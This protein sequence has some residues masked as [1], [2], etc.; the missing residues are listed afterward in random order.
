MAAFG[1]ARRCRPLV[2]A[3]PRLLST[4]ARTANEPASRVPLLIGGDFVDSAGEV[5]MPVRCPAT[6]RLLATAPQA[7]LAEMNAAV[8]AASAAF[9][10][11]SATSIS[12]RARV[13]FKLQALIREH[14]DELASILSSEHGKTIEDAKGDIFRGLEVVEHGVP[15]SRGSCHTCRFFSCLRACSSHALTLRARLFALQ[16]VPSLPCKWE[17]PWRAWQ[18]GRTST[19]SACRLACALEVRLRPCRT[20]QLSSM[21]RCA[22]APTFL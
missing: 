5:A 18:T 4:A 14:E 22:H 17:R 3:A 21:R 2:A 12:N 1:F 15:S 10:S 9:P 8:D 16:H 20:R 11:W 19:P 13:M 6:Q 7:T